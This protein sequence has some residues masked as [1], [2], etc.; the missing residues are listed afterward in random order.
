MA[1]A[2]LV[3]GISEILKKIGS[4]AGRE[5][6]L[7]WGVKGELKKLQKTADMIQ[8]VLQDAER[9]QRDTNAVKLWLQRLKQ[10][11][12][13]VEDILNE[14]AYE[15]LRKKI[16]N[17]FKNKV[18]NRFKNKLRRFVSA[19]NLLVF[20]LKM[21]H[22]IQG[23][24]QVFD[25][26]AKEKKMLNLKEEH[27][28]ADKPILDRGTFSLMDETEVFGR[29]N[30]KSAV[31]EMLRDDSSTAREDTISVIAIVGFGG[32]G[33][34]TLAQLV[35]NDQDVGECF[36][37]KEWVCV[38][39]DDS[40]GKTL[41]G[42]VFRHICDSEPRSLNKNEMGKKLE[43]KLKEKKLLLV[44]DDVWSCSQW[45]DVRVI[46]KHGAH[47]SKVIV[48]TRKQEVA[49]DMGAVHSLHLT[50][51][52]YDHC[53][54]LFKKRAFGRGGLDQTR[55]LE[56]IGREI[57]KKCHGV[58]LA[59]KA[60]GSLM[61]SKVT[62]REWK[63]IETCEYLDV[64]GDNV[65]NVLRLS[66]NHLPSPVK[67]CFQYCAIFPKDATIMKADLIQQWMA[68]GFI[69]CSN[70]LEMDKV[71]ND[72][73]K[74]LC[75]NSFFQNMKL[76]KNHDITSCKMHDLVHDLAQLIMGK[77]LW[78]L[79]H[80]TLTENVNLGETR[81]LTLR[82]DK[83]RE[84][85][86][87]EDL[88]KKL[89]TFISKRPVANDAWVNFK[90]IRVLHLND[91]K[92]VS[93]SICKLILLRYLS[94]LSY[95]L[96]SLPQSISQL[97]HL[98]TLNIENCWQL[99]EL[100][101]DMWKLTN[102]R[103]LYIAESTKILKKFGRL[104]S[105]RS[106]SPI[107]FLGEEEDGRGIGELECLN[108]LC[109]H[110]RIHNMESV[111]DASHVRKAKLMEKKKVYQL[112]MVWNEGA[113]SAAKG[114]K[115]DYSEVVEALEL[116]PNLIE[117]SI[118]G[119][120]G[121]KLQ[122]KEWL[123]NGSS[124][125]YLV[126]IKLQECRNL[127]E[128][129]P[130]WHIQPSLETLEISSMDKVKL[131]GGKCTSTIALAAPRLKHLTLRYMRVLEEWVENSTTPNSFPFLEE[132]IV[133]ECSML[134]IAPSDF[135]AVKE[136]KLNCVGK[137]GVSSLLSQ[138]SSL[139]SLQKLCVENF[140][141]LNLNL[142]SSFP[143]LKEIYISKIGGLDMMCSSAN[144][145]PRLH[146][147]PSLTSLDIKYVPEFIALPKGFLQSSSS[148]HLQSVFIWHC[149]KFQGFVDVEGS[150][151]PLLFSSNLKEIKLWSCRN[152]ESINV[153]G[154]TSLKT[155]EINMYKDL[156]SSVIGLQ[157]LQAL[158]NLTL[159][160]VP[161][162]MLSGEDAIGDGCCWPHLEI[163]NIL[164]SSNV[165]L[166]ASQLPS[167]TDLT[168]SDLF[169]EGQ[170]LLQ[171]CSKSLKKLHILYCYNFQGF[172]QHELQLFTS[173]KELRITNCSSLTPLELGSMVSLTELEI[174]NCKG[175]KSFPFSSEDLQCIPSLRRLVI[176]GFSEELDHLPFL[177]IQDSN[178]PWCSSLK[179]L[180]I[181]GWD[182]ITSLPDHLQH[183]TA[184]RELE[185]IQFDSLVALP[186]WLGNLSSLHSLTILRCR[187]L[188]HLPS[189][190]QL[191][192]LTLL[193]SVSIWNCPLLLDR[194]KPDGE[195]R[196]KIPDDYRVSHVA[197][198]TDFIIL[199]MRGCLSLPTIAIY[200]LFNNLLSVQVSLLFLL[201]C[202]LNF[203][204]IHVFFKKKKKKL[205]SFI[206]LV[207]QFG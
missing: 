167:L 19:S 102:L 185:I 194:L 100:P 25:D 138:P 72:Y 54:A 120:P 91:I 148:E 69:Q 79:S 134:R 97:Y 179:A 188:M 56:S 53:W 202:S 46:L 141:E 115:T 90:F 201:S 161:I 180:E 49:N 38:A 37:F 21:A 166:T 57:V 89:R 67:Q 43:E 50:D 160:G 191:Q 118:N 82:L 163:L 74:T 169:P 189:K 184:L 140:P 58:P 130:I 147:L 131:L 52:S 48:T 62:F 155:L 71:G 153:R 68:H 168:I 4:L 75:C 125:C 136:I 95:S 205:L 13:D 87:P 1:E 10:A 31:I 137:E 18:Q 33:K 135:P 172:T 5:V 176:G 77:E 8:K 144:N 40:S 42:E 197:F 187:G 86:F 99:K 11:A 45:D 64:V 126:E 83:E 193:D 17:H 73:F 151:L 96:T 85:S 143:S 207:L 154:L 157:S 63:D 28:G 122:L 206:Y 145:D 23:V 192:R 84:F 127:E 112:E 61:H 59:V 142:T 110:L 117:F 36:T 183:L 51:L 35:Y 39:N 9:R 204:S 107:L 114:T 101:D 22:R 121:V 190:Q 15:T 98:E 6:S 111:R 76:D 196:P 195:E 108:N 123:A 186:E 139:T 116:P 199:R 119:F 146:H 149:D 14:V 203:T 124:L 178:S 47:G 94:I 20:R 93:S 32:L 78:V 129:P 34:T 7:M 88:S 66:Y 152:L 159:D 2:I 198:S 104:H 177:P 55:N 181:R 174:I 30:E 24:N 150:E 27:A 182:K 92:E 70:D 109:G 170:G 106:I 3:N 175:I 164:G 29:E 200:C 113:K 103:H 41:L 105:L 12:Y 128:I 81:H 132:L 65:V 44:F 26:I 165:T 80:I 60:M 158:K 171:S 162:I 133:E 156:E 173:L 16:E